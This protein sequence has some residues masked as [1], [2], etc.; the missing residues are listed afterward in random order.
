M[1]IMLLSNDKVIE[2]AAKNQ[3]RK[4]KKNYKKEK[5]VFSCIKEKLFFKFDISVRSRG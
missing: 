1:G 4:E 2:K 5:S 3:K